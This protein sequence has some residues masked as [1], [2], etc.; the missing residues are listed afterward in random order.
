MK[1]GAGDSLKDMVARRENKT[2]VREGEAVGTEKHEGYHEMQKQR[3]RYN[4]W[5]Q[6]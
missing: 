4:R 6:P 1:G 3:Y 2:G 5:Y